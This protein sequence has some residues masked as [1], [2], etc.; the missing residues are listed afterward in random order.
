LLIILG[1]GLLAAWYI[2]LHPRY[3]NPGEGGVRLA[4]KFFSAAFHPSISES[5]RSGLFNAIV[6]TIKI[7][8]AAVGLS[9]MLGVVL[10]FFCR[11]A[12]PVGVRRLFRSLMSMLRSVHELLWATLFLAAFGMSPIAAVIALSIPY[13]GTFA[14]LYAEMI[15]E[16][17]R[18][19]ENALR[20]NGAGSLQVFLFAQLP[21][22][23][24]DIVSYTLYRFEC[25]LRSS[26]VMGFMGV[27]TLG[28]YIST[29][30]ENAYYHEVWAYLYVLILLVL[31]FE[32]WSDLLRHR[33]NVGVMA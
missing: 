19:P 4:K 11:E 1:C 9:V 18:G 25:A 12:S 5:G 15:D 16:M 26:A 14:K 6:Q 17:E 7:A 23:S 28:Y 31:F 32:K 10:S 20:A 21:M 13:T 27:T 30:Y 33:L 22:A 3:L 8:A 29:A 2:D 24:A